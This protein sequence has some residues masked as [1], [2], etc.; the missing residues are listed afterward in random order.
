MQLEFRNIAK[1][2]HLQRALDGVSFRAQRGEIIGIMG[3]NG[4]GKTTLI[5]LCALLA[6]PTH[7]HILVDGD[8]L[9]KIDR[10]RIGLMSPNTYLYTDLTVRENLELYAR[11]YRATAERRQ[12]CAEHF[13]LDPLLDRPVGELSHG[14]KNRASLARVMLGNPDLLLLDEPFLG[15]DVEATEELLNMIFRLRD[16]GALVLVATH[17]FDIAKNLINKLMILNCGAIVHF[18]DFANTHE[19]FVGFY[20]D[21]LEK[22]KKQ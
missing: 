3:P 12:E 13:D 11:L 15:L 4:A 10:G 6:K 16:R 8:P 14:Q 5:R 17:H 19:S 1:H 7:G 9:H 18:D 2:F 21:V 22:T 20:N